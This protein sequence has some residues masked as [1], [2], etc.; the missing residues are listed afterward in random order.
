MNLT[1]SDCI[2]QEELQPLVQNLH[3][4]LRFLMTAHTPVQRV[5]GSLL[6][7]MW[8][9]NRLQELSYSG[10]ADYT[11]ERLGISVREAQELA[12]LE[13]TIV[14]Y[15]TTEAFWM[16]GQIDRSKVRLILRGAKPEDD[17]LWACWSRC[18]TVRELE[19]KLLQP[20]DCPVEYR[21][22]E[23]TAEE[24]NGLEEALE[25]VDRL[26]HENLSTADALECI[27]AE[28]QAGAPHEIYTRALDEDDRSERDWKREQLRRRKELE[29]TGDRPWRRPYVPV[30]HPAVVPDFR[31]PPDAD[32]LT[33]DRVLRQACQFLQELDA[34][35]VRKLWLAQELKVYRTR[36]FATHVRYC[37]EEL[38]LSR[39]R[40]HALQRLR[41]K[42][43]P[44]VLEAY[45]T[46]V[47]SLSQAELVVEVVTAPT[48]Q[49]WVEYASRTTV[50][51][52]R[53]VVRD[54]RTLREQDPLKYGNLLPPLPS[55][56]TSPEGHALLDEA[57]ACMPPA[58]TEPM[59]A[60]APDC[61]RV[62]DDPKPLPFTRSGR[63]RIGLPADGYR[64][65]ASS[66][67][68]ATTRP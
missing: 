2:P 34:I 38:G 39:S 19:L 44:D 30:S 7:R 12:W 42:L 25:L 20:Q 48:A 24:R 3:E 63:V 18:L 60:C 17:T 36:G 46:G 61:P 53:K 15:P 57:L 49:A 13:R 52:L 8:E 16:S 33:V 11:R 22:F 56:D 5:I 67:I 66:G 54:S 41:G 26:C 43:L 45:A 35:V 68:P 59:P 62:P 21:E 4:E 9:A 29:A 10:T 50:R 6:N 51:K 58:A 1:L 28:L 27:A 23:L 32:T 47:L 55:T 31:V 37:V 65:A 14:H 40:T 64:S